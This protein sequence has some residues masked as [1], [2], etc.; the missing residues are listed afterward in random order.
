MNQVATVTEAAPL[1]LHED[2]EQR[3]EQFKAALPAHIPVERF[4]RVL[5][6]ALQGNPDLV[7][8][9]RRTLFTSAVKA[10]QDGLLPDGREGALVVYNTKSKLGGQE[11]W[12]K[13][14]QWLPMIAGIRKK[15]RNS[16]E[17]TTWNAHV[18]YD[19]DEFDY[20]LGMDDRL[21]H[22]PN[23]REDR[24]EPIAAYSIAKLKSGETSFEV[25]SAAEIIAVWSKSSKNKDKQGNPTGPWK[26]HAP[27]MWRKTVAKRHAKVLPMS[28]DLDD[29]M[30]RDDDLYDLEGASDKNIPDSG[31]KRPQLA[32]FTNPKP[33]ELTQVEGQQS[34]ETVDTETG[35]ITETAEYGAADAYNDGAKAKTDGK[36]LSDMPLEVR[37]FPN[38]N[39]AW[40]DGFSS[41]GEP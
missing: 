23:I 24:G 7:N 6:T 40:I 11:Q 1:K 30:R 21:H 8:A 33:V 17:I 9:D 34:T 38:L 39:E 25:M 12:I 37:Q 16:G 13:A 32:D 14:V 26:D 29:L 36:S 41:E 4:K 20:Q 19:K 35:E 27:E 22:K 2:I 10:A 15:V 31:A 3:T 18:V 5:L 28:T